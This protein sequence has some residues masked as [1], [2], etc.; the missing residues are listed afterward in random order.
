M[1]IFAAKTPETTKGLNMKKRWLRKEKGCR[2]KRSGG[3]MME[4]GGQAWY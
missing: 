3:R 1:G 4:D 2:T